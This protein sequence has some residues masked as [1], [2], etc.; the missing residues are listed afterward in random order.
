[1]NVISRIRALTIPIPVNTPNVRMVVILNTVSEKKPSAATMPAVSIAGPIRVTD[2]T[3]A[4]RLASDG[5]RVVVCRRRP[6]SS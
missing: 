4:A 2:S 6:Y 3:T 5:A 1:M